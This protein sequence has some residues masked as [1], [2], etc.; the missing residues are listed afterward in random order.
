MTA[1]VPAAPFVR[2]SAP[3]ILAPHVVKHLVQAAHDIAALL[4]CGHDVFQMRQFPL[5]ERIDTCHWAG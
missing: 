3:L 1:F 2:R 5:D 4:H